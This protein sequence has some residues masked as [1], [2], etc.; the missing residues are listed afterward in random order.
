M[1]VEES[2]QFDAPPEVV[3]NSLTD[4]DRMDRWLPIGVRAR[5]LSADRLVVASDGYTWHYEFTAVPA[6]LRLSWRAMDGPDVDGEADVDD[7]GAGGSVVHVQ[8]N[9][10]ER[11][12]RPQIRQ[13]LHEAMDRLQR[14]VSDN[15]NAG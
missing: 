6:E 10:D 5:L 12:D 3:F 14:D 7:A 13:Y 9:A 11:V 1:D 4:P 2:F 8:L 15:F